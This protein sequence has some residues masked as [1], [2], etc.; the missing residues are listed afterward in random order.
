MLFM[1]GLVTGIAI[2]CLIEFL[3]AHIC[4]FARENKVKNWEG[5]RGTYGVGDKHTTTD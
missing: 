4:P 5:K 2:C 3:Y 1:L